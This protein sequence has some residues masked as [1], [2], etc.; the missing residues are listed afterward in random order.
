MPTKIRSRHIDFTFGI[1]ENWKICTDADQDSRV[2]QDEEE[3]SRAGKAYRSMEGS[4]RR[5]P[6]MKGSRRRKAN[7]LSPEME[8]GCVWIAGGRDRRRELWMRYGPVSIGL[9]SMG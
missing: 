4:R 6:E 9:F 7:P 2:E 5:T 8:V 3:D 1:A